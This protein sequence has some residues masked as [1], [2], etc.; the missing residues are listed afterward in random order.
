[1]ALFGGHLKSSADVGYV[2]VTTV[3]LGLED[4]MLN[5]SLYPMRRNLEARGYRLELYLNGYGSKLEQLHSRSKRHDFRLDKCAYIGSNE[6]DLPAM[7]EVGLPI[8][9]NTEIEEVRKVAKIVVEGRDLKKLL[10]YFPPIK[11]C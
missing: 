11:I 10:K 1:M 8:A 2:P 5:D 6:S 3:F 9:F 4:E 7:K